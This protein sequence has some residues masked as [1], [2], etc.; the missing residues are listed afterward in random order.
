MVGKRKKNLGP[1]ISEIMEEFNIP[2]K[3]DF[4]RLNERL[5]ELENLLKQ[6][7]LA[8]SYNGGKLIGERKPGKKVT[9]AEMVFNIVKKEKKPV[10]F[11]L[12]KEKTGFDDKKLRNI[13]FRLHATKKIARVER[14][15]YIPE[16]KTS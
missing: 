4:D 14:G 16:D 1:I 12:L 9:A 5:T 13:I 3:K 15:C 11:K 7:A 8:S 10:D 2:T 6:L